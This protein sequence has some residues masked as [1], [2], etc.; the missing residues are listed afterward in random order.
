MQLL[1]HRCS[2]CGV[3][4][5]APLPMISTG[6]AGVWQCEGCDQFH[7]IVIECRCISLETLQESP[8]GA[9]ANELCP[10]AEAGLAKYQEHQEVSARRSECIERELLDIMYETRRL[11]E[12]VQDLEDKA[13]C[14]LVEKDGYALCADA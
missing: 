4:T 10:S 2:S 1:K 12:L 3:T 7:N 8:E 11:R 13:E 14:L 6:N 5:L 9:P